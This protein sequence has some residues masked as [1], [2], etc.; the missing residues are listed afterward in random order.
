FCPF[1]RKAISETNNLWYNI[2]E[3]IQAGK[4]HRERAEDE[5]HISQSGLHLKNQSNLFL[6]QMQSGAS[7]LFLAGPK[8]LFI[9]F[10]S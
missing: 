8:S 1:F 10:L 5:S 6:G 9:V 4:Y 3:V 2:L 7:C